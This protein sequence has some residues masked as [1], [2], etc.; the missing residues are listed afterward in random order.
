VLESV[1]QHGEGL[2][3]AF[4]AATVRLMIRLGRDEAE[5]LI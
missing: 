3:E 5:K 4:A 2:V 1:V